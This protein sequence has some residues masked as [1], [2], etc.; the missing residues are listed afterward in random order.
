ML[1]V[2]AALAPCSVLVL[3]LSPPSSR[4]R[5][6]RPAPSPA[7]VVKV[8]GGARLGKY[9][10]STITRVTNRL[11]VEHV[12]LILLH[13]IWHGNICVGAPSRVDDAG[14]VLSLYV[15]EPRIIREYD[16]T[17]EPT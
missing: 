3:P 7:V 2:R 12:P 17:M 9:M 8:T 15:Y 6:P 11:L 1:A 16:D 14:H 5:W 13:G 4:G 10:A